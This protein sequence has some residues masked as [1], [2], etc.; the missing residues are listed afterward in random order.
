MAK[1][2]AERQAAYRAR[3]AFSGD[4]G[5]GERRLNTWINTAASLALA[6]LAR[7]YSVTQ[8]AI[9]ECLI[10][11]EDERILAGIEFD[12]LEWANYFGTASLRSRDVGTT[13]ENGGTDAG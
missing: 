2:A 5:T 7:R 6:R 11:A 13:Q 1:T 12:T 9:L 10:L 8:R 3:R 4:D